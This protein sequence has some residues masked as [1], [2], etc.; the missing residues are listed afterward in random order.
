MNVYYMKHYRA[1]VYYMK[2]YCPYSG[3]VYTRL[4]LKSEALYLLCYTIRVIPTVR[5]YSG[6][7]FAGLRLLYDT[8]TH[9]MY[10]TVGEREMRKHKPRGFYY[11][12]RRLGVA[13]P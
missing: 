5:V 3:R 6:A 4:L 11:E 10:C 1:F 2:H 9:D 8:V 12:C 13:K 7:C